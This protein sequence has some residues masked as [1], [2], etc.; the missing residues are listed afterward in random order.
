VS[1]ST[2]SADWWRSG[3]TGITDCAGEE[4]KEMQDFI[5]QISDIGTIMVLRKWIN[6]LFVPSP[7]MK[8]VSPMLSFHLPQFNSDKVELDER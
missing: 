3:D 2:I 7:Q 4:M 5:S 8:G 6:S 1:R